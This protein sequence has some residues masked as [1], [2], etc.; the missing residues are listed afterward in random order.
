MK[1]RWYQTRLLAPAWPDVLKPLCD[2]LHD[3]AT[4]L[5]LDHDLAEFDAMLEANPGVIGDDQRCVV[6]QLIE[7]HRL[8]RRPGFWVAG[9][10]FYSEKPKAYI[11]RIAAWWEAGSV[12]D[13]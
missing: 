13:V 8:A 7:R 9:Y 1:Y 11:R 10:R 3:L 2:G 6:G 5:G 12:A 4:Q